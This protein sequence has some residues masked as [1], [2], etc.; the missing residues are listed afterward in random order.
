MYGIIISITTIT[1][2]ITITTTT[3]PSH[4]NPPPHP[5]YI[6]PPSFSFLSSPH[7]P[8]LL[9][10]ALKKAVLSNKCVLVLPLLLSSPPSSHIGSRFFKWQ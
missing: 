7:T 2:I 8:L 3:I 4:S 10:Q 6:N 5:Q 1:T 9:Y